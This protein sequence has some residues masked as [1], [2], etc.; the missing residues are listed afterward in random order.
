M[1]LKKRL[2]N[3]IRGWLPKPSLP[4]DKLKMAEAGTKVSKPQWWRLY[5]TTLLIVTIALGIAT[6][7]LLKVPLERA[8]IGL[9]LAIIGISSAYYIRVRPSIRANRALYILLGITP[10][11]F[12]LWIIWAVSGIGRLITDTVGALPSLLISWVVCCSI[13]AL[14]GDRI[15]KRRNYQIPLSP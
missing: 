13:G 8:T 3:F 12:F 2:E 5:W 10:I 15:G 7:L 11:G 4:S 14:I 9:I 1:H 6:Y